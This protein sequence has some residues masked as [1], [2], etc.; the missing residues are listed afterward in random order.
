MNTTSSSSSS[1][2]SN[3]PQNL[4]TLDVSIREYN[5]ERPEKRHV[6][7]KDIEQLKQYYP[8]IETLAEQAF[9]Q[10]RGEGNLVN[11]SRSDMHNPIKV[12]CSQSPDGDEIEVYVT[13]KEIQPEKEIHSDDGEESSSGAT[14]KMT[15]AFQLVF[16]PEDSSSVQLTSAKPVARIT[17]L[18]NPD[19]SLKEY[20]EKCDNVWREVSV[21]R[22]A[23]A[24]SSKISVPLASHR[25]IGRVPYQEK[26]PSKGKRTA[27][28]KLKTATTEKVTANKVVS[29]YELFDGDLEKYVRTRPPYQSNTDK[30]QDVFAIFIQMTEGLTDSHREKVVHNDIKLENFLFRE[31]KVQE[32][33]SLLV[34]KPEILLTDFDIADEKIH[35]HNQP[36]IQPGTYSYNP[37]EFFQRNELYSF[38]NDAWAMGCC[39]REL[40]RQKPVWMPLL[41]LKGA[42]KELQEDSI[43]TATPVTKKSKKAPSLINPNIVASLIENLNTRIEEISR[44]AAGE[45]ATVGPLSDS[46]ENHALNDQN[47]GAQACTRVIEKI[48]EVL[49]EGVLNENQKNQLEN[50]LSNLHTV[51]EAKLNEVWQSLEDQ[52]NPLGNRTPEACASKQVLL[53]YLVWAM[54]RPNPN[55][56]I[57]MNQ[58]QNLMQR[59]ATLPSVTETEENLLPSTAE[60]IMTF[61]SH[62]FK[63]PVNSSI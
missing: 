63:N 31:K 17:L 30:Y 46:N 40:L 22:T 60:K 62:F 42:L 21:I 18:Y 26:M 47:K 2:S 20:L 54:N 32:E 57:K 24:Q 15:R 10:L 8:E 28:G 55:E 9:S 37:P 49:K 13:I 6:S 34:N 1:S 3:T 61:F 16:H 41:I 48:Q 52:P 4:S 5:R 59:A 58:V 43:Q 38:S 14:K 36:T 7:D 27:E 11:Y 50:I 25:Y 51:I 19:L 53:H 45:V 12:Q 39:L 35:T 33:S 29:Y 44:Y 23:A 56:R